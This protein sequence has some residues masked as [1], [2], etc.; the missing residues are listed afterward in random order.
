MI[1]LPERHYLAAIPFPG[2]YQSILDST[3]DSEIE[4]DGHNR[5]KD[6]SNEGDESSYPQSIRLDSSEVCEAYFASGVSDFI[7]A[8]LR[9][10][11]DYLAAFDELLTGHLGYRT[12]LQF[13]SMESPREYNFTT[14]TLYAWIPHSTVQLLARAMESE[15]F[16]ERVRER[17][18]HRSGFISSYS[19][20][21]EHYREKYHEGGPAALDHNEIE[22][23]LQAAIREAGRISYR[24]DSPWSPAAGEDPISEIQSRAEME[25]NESWCSN[26]TFSEFVDWDTL[27]SALADKRAAKLPADNDGR[28]AVLSELLSTYREGFDGLIAAI[29]RARVAA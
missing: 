1:M 22:T 5:C 15:S 19:N 27:E 9:L 26:G 3:I 10:A 4:S 7:F 23:V 16:A 6:A 8:H 29:E 20:D 12:R 11:R 17:H 21:P 13:E 14:D 24:N 25:V 18:S 28:V 2:L